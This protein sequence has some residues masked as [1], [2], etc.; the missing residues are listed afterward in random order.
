M[1]NYF[2]TKSK[3]GSSYEHNIYTASDNAYG[4]L[5][6]YNGSGHDRYKPS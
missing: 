5:K 4:K 6:N 1:R 3:S 2:S